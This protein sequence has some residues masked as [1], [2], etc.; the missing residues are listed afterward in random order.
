MR[1]LFQV[2]DTPEGHVTRDYKE[3]LARLSDLRFKVVDTSGMAVSNTAY[4]RSN[5]CKTTQNVNVVAGLEPNAQPGTI[6]ARTAT[7]TE[8]VLAGSTIALFMLDAR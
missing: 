2:H 1:C 6:Q 3:G 7:L 8:G 4:R 5:Q